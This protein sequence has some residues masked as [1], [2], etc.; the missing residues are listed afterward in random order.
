MLTNSERQTNDGHGEGDV[1]A[2]AEEDPI[3]EPA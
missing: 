2:G 1:H 3:L